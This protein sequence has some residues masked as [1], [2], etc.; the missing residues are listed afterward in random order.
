MR[1]PGTRGK[2]HIDQEK[3]E[4]R[5]QARKDLQ[6]LLEL[7]D[8]EGYVKFLKALRPDLKPEELSSLVEGFREE[9]RNR[10]RD[11]PPRP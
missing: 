7:G 11:F 1:K 3:V 8:E 5:E 9:R 10:S 4:A 2:K 6:R